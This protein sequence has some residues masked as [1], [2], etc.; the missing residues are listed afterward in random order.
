[1]S[2]IKISPATYKARIK[3]KQP[4]ENGKTLGILSDPVFAND[5]LNVIAETFAERSYERE[6]SDFVDRIRDGIGCIE[7]EEIPGK[8][9]EFFFE[10]KDEFASNYLLFDCMEMLIKAQ[11]TINVLKEQRMHLLKENMVHEA[12]LSPE[13][14]E[15]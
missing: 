3:N 6:L 15:E 13:H 4:I 1:M 7:S 12:C 8:A 5:D 14:Q 10:D 11:I 2:I 9:K